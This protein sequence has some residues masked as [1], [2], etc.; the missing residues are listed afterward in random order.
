MYSEDS[1]C[2]NRNDPHK[3]GSLL[4]EADNVGHSADSHTH[5][6]NTVA[7]W[8]CECVKKGHGHWLRCEVGATNHIITDVPDTLLKLHVAWAANKGNM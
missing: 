1:V 8:W 4:S 7:I 5:Q 3:S 2:T 6:C